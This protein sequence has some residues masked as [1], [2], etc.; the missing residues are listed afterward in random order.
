[1]KIRKSKE[2]DLLILRPVG[3]LDSENS[4]IFE[5]TIEEAVERGETSLIADLSEITYM[6]SRGLRTFLGGAK[7]AKAA[8][9]K[10]VVCAAQ[11]PVQKVFDMTGVAALFGIFGSYEDAVRCFEGETSTGGSAS[12]DPR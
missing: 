8:G 10:L 9:G 6:S 7:S 4:P 11:E 1:M 3:R 5:K 2:G 12:A